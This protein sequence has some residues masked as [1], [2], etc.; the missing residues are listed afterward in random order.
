MLPYKTP[1]TG[2]DKTFSS[3]Y[4]SLTD[5]GKIIYLSACNT[6]SD[7]SSSSDPSSEPDGLTIPVK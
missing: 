7:P 4:I 6:L 1:S 5:K 2:N 3:E